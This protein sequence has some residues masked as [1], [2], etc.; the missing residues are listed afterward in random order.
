MSLQLLVNYYNYYDYYY[1]C[2]ALFIDHARE[3]ESTNAKVSINRKNKNTAN[4][5]A[6]H[7]NNN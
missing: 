1:H 6:V 3:Q 5:W 2:I 4:T 7:I